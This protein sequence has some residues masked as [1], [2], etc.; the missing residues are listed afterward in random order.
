MLRFYQ[1][2]DSFKANT[3]SE[4]SCRSTTSTRTRAP[5][6]A[7]L[8]FDLDNW[9]SR[10]DEFGKWQIKSLAYHLGC[11]LVTERFP[12]RK[13]S[14]GTHRVVSGYP[15][16]RQSTFHADATPENPFKLCAGAILIMTSSE[17]KTTNDKE[18]CTGLPD[19]R[20]PSGRTA[21]P[22]AT[23]RPMRLAT[24]NINGIRA[25]LDYMRAWLDARQP[26][27]VG[28]QETKIQDA[29]FPHVVLADAGYKAVVHGQKS[30]NGVAV[31]SREDVSVTHA[32][33][34]GRE[35]AGARLITV[36]QNGLSFTSV[37]VPNGKSVEHDDYPK[38]LDWFETLTSHLEATTDMQGAAVVGGDF[39]IVPTGLDSWDEER[40]HGSV[41]HTDAERERL[42][43]LSE[44]GFEDLW[45]KLHPDDQAFSWWDYRGGS[46]HR[47]HGLRIDFLFGTPAVAARTREV[48]IDRDWRKKVDGLTA[49]DHAPVYVDL[50]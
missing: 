39:N 18:S 9:Y 47:K 14:D 20:S 49:S 2:F 41:F 17:D 3:R 19:V 37:Y 29:D 12:N 21:P 38:K 7:V 27:L 33:L 8:S 46:F 36:E 11:L 32:W 28:L 23:L 45:R 4:T 16:A 31:L 5:N 35:D 30:W 48:V 6:K 40:F 10:N 26:D 50:D 24:W 22:I 15:Y 44:I 25:R 43:R 13:N 34:P 42:A 1:F